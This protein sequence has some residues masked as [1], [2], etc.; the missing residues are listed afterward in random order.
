[1]FVFLYDK[2]FLVLTDLK[3]QTCW[4]QGGNAG[5][6]SSWTVYQQKIHVCRLDIDVIYS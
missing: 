2:Y 1:M 3:V 4:I 6:Y 5:T